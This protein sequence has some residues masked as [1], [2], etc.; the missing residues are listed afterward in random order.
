M[1]EES[2]ISSF[3]GLELEPEGTTAIDPKTRALVRLGALV[4]ADGAPASFSWAVEVAL[5]S[6]A[7]D[8]EV[9]GTLVAVAP[10]I[11]MA[12]VVSA[13]P[14]IAIAL[15]CPVETTLELIKDPQERKD[16]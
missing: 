13:A 15:G 14:E 11:G 12:R 9:I 5:A 6:G 1:N 2:S 4:G 3:L 10:V 16:Q 7:T 8:E